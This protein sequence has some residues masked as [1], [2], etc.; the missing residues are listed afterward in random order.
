MRTEHFSE[1]SLFLA[2]QSCDLSYVI[3]IPV[4]HNF[5]SHNFIAIDSDSST[6]C[7]VRIHDWIVSREAAQ[8]YKLSSVKLYKLHY[9][10]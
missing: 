1:E 6:E 3:C 2:V 10:S 7:S 9:I 8:V 4:H 5:T